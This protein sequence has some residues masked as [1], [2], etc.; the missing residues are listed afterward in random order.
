[1]NGFRL[2]SIGGFEIRIDFSW[3][4]ILFLIVWS[5]S[6]AVFPAQVPGYAQG[7]YLIMGVSGALL[8]FASLLGHELAHSFVARRR[9]IEVEG[10]TLFVFGGMARTRSEAK[11]PGDEFVIAG[12]GPLASLALAGLLWL[13][14]RLG[15]EAGL[16]P[17]I[18]V[19]LAYL[20]WLNLLLAVFNMLPGFPLDGG[21]V[22][23]AIAWRVTGSLEKATRLA[24]GGGRLLGFLLAGIGIYMAFRVDVVGGLW[25]V[26]IGWYLRTAAV[27]SY[28]QHRLRDVLTD[29]RADQ[30]M[31]PSPETVPP[32]ITLQQ[33]MDDVFMRSRYVAFP[34][35]ENG[36]PI[37]LVT[38]HQLREVARD[39]WS[40][41][42]VR[43]VM[44]PIEPALVV[45]P[46]DTV[47]T[48]IDRLQ[49][50]PA[51]RVLVM[52][53]GHLVGIISARDITHWLERARQLEEVRR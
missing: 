26:F 27:A 48:V 37:G 12:V 44:L 52:Q 14:A 34:V 28:Q 53:D 10:I 13:A 3:F 32:D 38:L 36:T 35:V 9:G 11:S 50:S 21:R 20:A 5:F 24:T 45:A 43:E 19:V 8:F 40:Y 1:M 15:S 16:S 49:S 6:F 47:T 7:A 17:V 23:R 22:L 41:I 25:L 51:R 29:V 42:P 46:D 30:T 31:S 33:L 39:S 4:I 18:T 2:G